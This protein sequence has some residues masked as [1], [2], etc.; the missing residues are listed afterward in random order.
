[1]NTCPG[2]PQLAP[3][4]GRGKLHIELAYIFEVATALPRFAALPDVLHFL[5]ELTGVELRPR[6]TSRR[7][8]TQAQIL[9]G[10]L[11][12]AGKRGKQTRRHEIVVISIISLPRIINGVRAGQAIVDF[13][14][15]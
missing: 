10:E 5:F 6:A 4:K 13:R 8:Q 11:M 2:W 7:P 12:M 14:I 3:W 15:G 9:A 1:V